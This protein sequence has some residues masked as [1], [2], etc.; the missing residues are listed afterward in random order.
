MYDAPR[1]GDDA[2]L[3]GELRTDGRGRTS[4]RR[5]VCVDIFF[6]PRTHMCI[7]GNVL[8][9]KQLC[10][11]SEKLVRVGGPTACAGTSNSLQIA[12]E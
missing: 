12:D 1:L 4:G 9:C 6:L 11:P 5:G 8:L 10:K 2:V 3:S 7:R